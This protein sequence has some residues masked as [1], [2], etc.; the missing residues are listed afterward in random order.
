MTTGS[1]FSG[2][3]GIVLQ[4]VTVIASKRTAPPIKRLIFVTKA[5]FVVF[6]YIKSEKQKK[7]EKEFIFFEF[8][9]DFFVRSPLFWA[10]YICE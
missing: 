10:Y 3:C 8:F 5:D 7:S 9:Y 2:S 1:F 6:I 4:A